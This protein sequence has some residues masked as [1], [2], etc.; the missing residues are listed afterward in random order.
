ME[1]VPVAIKL[2]KPE[3]APQATVM[4]RAGN[5][6][7]ILVFQPVNAGMLNVARPV[8]PHTKIPRSARTV[9]YTHLHLEQ[10][11]LMDIHGIDPV[12]VDDGSKP[13][14]GKRDFRMG[15]FPLEQPGVV[16]GGKG[17]FPEIIQP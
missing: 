16:A 12:V 3:H 10:L 15:I 8:K 4:N 2:W 7:P 9:S 11:G 5:R 6:V 13:W 1:E 17:I 14:A